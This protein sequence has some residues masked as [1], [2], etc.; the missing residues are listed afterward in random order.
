MTAQEAVCGACL[1]NAT[2]QAPAHAKA[3][4]RWGNWCYRQGTYLLKTLSGSGARAELNADEEGRL[5]QL[6]NEQLPGAKTME[7]VRLGAVWAQLSTLLRSQASA[8]LVLPRGRSA[9]LLRS[10]S[11]C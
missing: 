7:P 1:E 11:S 3:Q 4:L 5:R 2:K 9:R 10:P 6:V 8:A